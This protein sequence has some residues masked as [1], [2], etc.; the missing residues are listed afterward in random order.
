MELIRDIGIKHYGRAYDGRQKTQ[1]YSVFFCPVCKKEVEKSKDRGKRT[2]SCGCKSF[3][4]GYYTRLHATWASMKQRCLDKNHHKYHRYG[5]RGITVCKEW[6]EFVNFRKW[7]LKN[8]YKDDLTIDREDNDGNYEP[9]NCQ[10]I[11]SLENSRKRSDIKLSM[12]KAMEIREL[13]A[14][15]DYS[16]NRLSKIYDVSRRLIQFILSGKAWAEG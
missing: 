10:F 12:A 3:H 15:G 11:T 4:G 14:T 16:K 9:S 8:G 7:A 5:G 2:K 1:M 13:F 6:M